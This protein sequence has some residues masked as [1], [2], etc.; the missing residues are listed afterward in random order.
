MTGLDAIAGLER[1]IL[2]ESYVLGF[3]RIGNDICVCMNFLLDDGSFR[4]GAIRFST[5]TSEEWKTSAGELTSME[6]LGEVAHRYYSGGPDASPDLGDLDSICL[7][8][9]EWHL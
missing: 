2:E 3:R 5:V 6:R 1:V 4:V 9:D 8:Q 7:I